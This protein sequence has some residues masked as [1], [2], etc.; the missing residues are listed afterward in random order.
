MYDELTIE[1]SPSSEFHLTIDVDGASIQDNL[2]KKLCDSLS[3][4]ETIHLQIHLKKKIPIGAGLGGG[5][6]NVAA[7]LLFLKQHHLIQANSD[8]L[9]S[10]AL[11]CGAD[12]P[13]FLQGGTALVEGIGEKI[14]P[15]KP[16]FKDKYFLLIQPPFALSTS[17]MYKAL[18][19]KKK[20]SEQQS[21]ESIYSNLENDFKAIAWEMQPLYS[22]LE[23][24]LYQNY[25]EK[26]YL[27][28]SGSV[29]FMILS[30][31]EEAFHE[32]ALIPQLKKDFP[33]LT[34]H[35]CK[36]VKESKFN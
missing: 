15:I 28:G 11:N 32:K 4:Q 33:E 34:L 10:I 1:Y 22:A 26:I 19:Q 7:L 30:K 5:S 29:C 9:Q 3:W 16:I 2:L 12:V 6:S 27:S 21:F 36:S 20:F 25:S 14:Q 13:F 23:T 17:E 35:K 31:S 24:Y 18:D 8:Q